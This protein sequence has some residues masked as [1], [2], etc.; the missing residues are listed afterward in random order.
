MNATSLDIIKRALAA[1]EFGEEPDDALLEALQNGNL[2]Y[3]IED[4]E[5]DSLQ[6]MEFCISIELSTGAQFTEA[7]F[8][9]CKTLTDVATWLA[10][11]SRSSDNL[12][13]DA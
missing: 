13:A 1:A 4:L 8:S 3:P 12:T 6:T 9:N 5:Y 11:Q 7:V 2:D 10:D